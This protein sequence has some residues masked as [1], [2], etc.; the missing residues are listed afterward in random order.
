MHTALEHIRNYLNHS[1]GVISQRQTGIQAQITQVDKQLNTLEHRIDRRLNSV[2]KFTSELGRLEETH[3]SS[4][5]LSKSLH[6]LATKL[7]EINETLD[8]SERLPIFKFN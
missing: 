6:D 1:A 8:E 5:K 7:N 4:K 3:N 2:S